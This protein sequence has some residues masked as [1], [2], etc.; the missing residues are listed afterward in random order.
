MFD[1]LRA[2]NLNYA[3]TFDLA[4]LSPEAGRGLGLVTCIDTRIEPLA[5]LGLR[6]GDAK[7]LRNAGGRVTDDVLRSLVLATALLGVN[8]IAIMHHTKCALAG[9]SDDQLRSALGTEQRI[10][11]SDWTFLAMPEPDAALSADVRTVRNCPALP[12][13]VAVEGWRFDVDTGLVHTIVAIDG[14][15]IDSGSND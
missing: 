1:D 12:A 11:T 10:A 15:S 14:A 9:R 7:I 2:A 8:R 4:G 13:D 3:A 6:P 5:A